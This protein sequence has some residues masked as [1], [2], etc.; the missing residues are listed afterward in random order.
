MDDYLRA[1]GLE[2]FEEEGGLRIMRSIQLDCT[3]CH[4]PY[5]Q[6]LPGPGGQSFRAGMSQLSSLVLLILAERVQGVKNDGSTKDM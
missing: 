5:R 1:G 6:S 2:E 3:S 4:K